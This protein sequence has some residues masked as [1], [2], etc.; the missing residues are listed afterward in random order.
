MRSR[1][2]TRAS[3]PRRSSLLEARARTAESDERWDEALTAWRE[4]AGLE[5]SLES[6]REG[7]ARVDAARGT[8]AAHRRSECEAGTP[9]GCG[10]RAEARGARADGGGGRQPAR[11]AGCFGAPGSSGSRRPAQSPV[12]LR[13][14]SDGQ[15]QVAIYRVGQYGTF[16]T[17]DVRVAARGATPSSARA[18]DFAT[19]GG[20]WSCR[21]APRPRPWSSDAR[22]RFEGLWLEDPLG[23][24]KIAPAELPLTVGGPGAAV[25]IPGC[26]PGEVRARVALTDA[27]ASPSR[28]SRAR[29]RMRSTASPS[30]SRTAD[31]RATIVV[32]HGGVAN[33]TR[34]PQAN[35]APATP[36]RTAIASRSRSSPYEPRVAASATMRAPRASRRAGCAWA[37]GARRGRRRALLLLRR[38]PV[39]VASNPGCRLRRASNFDGTCLDFGFGG[40]Y[41]VPPGDYELRVEADGYRAGESARQ[42][43]QR[44]RASATSSRSSA[45]R[46]ASPSTP[47]ASPRRSRWTAARSASCPASTSCRPARA[48]SPSTAPHLRR[49]AAALRGHGRRR[50]AGAQ[51]QA[52]AAS[53]RASA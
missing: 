31:G 37:R 11:A 30:R 51:G 22:S 5:P 50:A 28:P 8:A 43:R 10:G 17:R 26:R 44:S 23:E 24:R 18:A 49:G 46:A 15:T 7:I 13:L 16:A 52:R 4:A 41:L 14:E 20:R 29:G 42:G 1:R 21:R 48:S 25:V 36:R 3:A 40:R 53:S 47:A 32:R 34:P 2:S 39:Q 33:V 9:V 35:A 12:R 38:P 45:C 27:T 19:C 6:A